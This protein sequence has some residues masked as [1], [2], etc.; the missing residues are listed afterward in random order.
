MYGATL[1]AALE[2][3]AAAAPAWAG[4]GPRT[5]LVLPPACKGAGGAGGGGGVAQP[6]LWCQPGGACTRCQLPAPPPMARQGPGLMTRDLK[7]SKCG[8]YI[9]EPPPSIMRRS[10]LSNTLHAGLISHL[11]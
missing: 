7:G 9:A 10:L 6:K 3:A 2:G 8:G 5:C 1:L 11:I 4:S